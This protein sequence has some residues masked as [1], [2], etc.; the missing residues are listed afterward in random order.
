MPKILTLPLKISRNQLNG[1]ADACSLL[2]T[3]RLT[4]KKPP[5]R[6][7]IMWWQIIG[8]DKRVS[9]N[10]NTSRKNIF[11]K[12]IFENKSVLENMLSKV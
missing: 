1:G 2:L 3:L 7:I 5:Q 11:E 10:D 9:D 4:P 6:G 8:E 12:Y